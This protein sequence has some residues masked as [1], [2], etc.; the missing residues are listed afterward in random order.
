MNQ[1][2]ESQR[3]AGEP[4]H[5]KHRT[6]FVGLFILVPL[7]ILP[8]F[9][10]YTF[11]RTD[12]L[13]KW[14]YLYVKYETAGG[15]ARNGAVTILDMNVGRVESVSLNPLGHIDVKLK[16]KRE[17]LS[18]IRRDSKARLRQKNVAIGD[19][20]VDIS[21]GSSEALPV[22]NGDTLQSEVQAPLATTLDQVSKTVSTLQKL[23][24]NILDGKGTVG[25][26]MKE[27]TLVTIAQDVGRNANKLVRN[28]CGTLAH[29]DT[30]LDKVAAI[31]EK[32]KG[33]ADSVAGIASKVGKLVTDLNF[34]VNS[35]Q[36]SSRDLPGLMNRVQGDISEIEL[37]LKA[38]QSNAIVK[39]GINSQADPL[40]NDNPARK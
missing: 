17:Y 16:I 10:I 2:A 39:S 37:L 29:V 19:W 9:L 15:V 21:R 13:T 12:L 34:L 35:I 22:A 36:T 4:F 30:V 20:E 25:R 5:R 32:G 6:F 40:L 7:V 38:L 11:L 23:L 14:D 33:I 8:V 28:A 18:F 31:G 1:S 27:D 3:S 24:Q 26:L